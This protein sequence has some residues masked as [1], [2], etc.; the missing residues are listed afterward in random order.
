MP[1]DSLNYNLL[2][3][4]MKIGD[5]QLLLS[6]I[7]KVLFKIKAA[8]SASFYLSLNGDTLKHLETFIK[9]MISIT[10]SNDGSA[11]VIVNQLI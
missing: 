5:Y 1:S 7:H 10:P 11:L 9:T 8:L 4:N 3:K 6:A 2:F